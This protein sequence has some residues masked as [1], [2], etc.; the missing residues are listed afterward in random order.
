MEVPWNSAGRPLRNVSDITSSLFNWDLFAAY[1]RR[2]TICD[3]Q[4]GTWKWRR[5]RG[6]INV[7]YTR[8]NGG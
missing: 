1:L 5:L 4:A 6:H 3:L 7:P 2:S 8:A